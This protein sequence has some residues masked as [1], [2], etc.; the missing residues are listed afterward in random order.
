MK[1][2]ISLFIFCF[3]GN[4]GEYAGKVELNTEE[5][6]NLMQGIIDILPD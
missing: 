5:K 6:G 4:A 2:R 1:D 3:G